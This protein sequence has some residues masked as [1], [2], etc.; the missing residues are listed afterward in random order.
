MKFN[1]AD[2][3]TGAQKLVVIEDDKK[4]RH[5]YDK[6]ISQEVPGNALGDEYE[7][8]K[9]KITGGFDKEGFPMKQ[10]I[11]VPDRVR[12]LLSK[13]TGCYRP[14]RTGQRRRKS[15]RGCI[16]SREISVLHLIVTKKGKEAIPG[17]TDRYLPRRLGPKRASKIRKLFN[18]TK[19]DKVT[20]YVVRREVPSKK[21]GK[22]PRSKAPKIQ[23]LVTPRVLQ[24]K[25]VRIA[26]RKA[27]RVR[28]KTEAAAYAAL[29]AQRKQEKRAALSSK[30]S[31][32]A[33]AKKSIKKPEAK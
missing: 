13:A 33:S 28:S 11:L 16:V 25:R 27:Q 17:L 21:E 2:P 20:Q 26:A 5:V 30:K 14:K 1:I 3:S 12:L 31:K 29:L 4:L 9:F 32:A 22:K 7:D 8:Y 23:R 15:V 10:G 6:R 18:L 24:R 19:E